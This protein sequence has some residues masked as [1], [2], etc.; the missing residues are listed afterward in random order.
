MKH[1]YRNHPS[2]KNFFKRT[3]NLALIYVLILSLFYQAT[4]MANP[5]MVTQNIMETIMVIENADDASAA[6]IS[7]RIIVASRLS[8]DAETIDFLGKALKSINSARLEEARGLLEM[9]LRRNQFQFRGEYLLRAES[10]EKLVKAFLFGTISKEVELTYRGVAKERALALMLTYIADPRTI[11]TD[12]DV[13]KFVDSQNVGFL[14]KGNYVK[15]PEGLD[16]RKIVAQLESDIMAAIPK[17]LPLNYSVKQDGPSGFRTYIEII[18]F[19]YAPTV[20]AWF[21]NGFR[22][23]G[24]NR[25]LYRVAD[26]FHYLASKSHGQNFQTLE[27]LFAQVESVF[28]SPAIST[29]WAPRTADSVKAILNREFTY[30]ADAA[31]KEFERVIAY[32]KST[33]QS[34]AMILEKT[35]EYEAKILANKEVLVKKLADI[36]QAVD[37]ATK[38]PGFDKLSGHLKD[39]AKLRAAEKAGKTRLVT[40]DMALK[41]L[42]FFIAG[43]YAY[44]GTWAVSNT[45]NSAEKV[46]LMQKYSAKTINSLLYMVPVAGE[47]AI[48]WDFSVLAT[49]AA[50][51]KFLETDFRL[52]H[53]ED[54]IRGFFRL[55]EDIAVNLFVGVDRH[56]NNM[57]Y[58]EATIQMTPLKYYNGGWRDVVLER[59]SRAVDKHDVDAIRQLKEGMQIHFKKTAQSWIQAMYIAHTNHNVFTFDDTTNFDLEVSHQVLDRYKGYLSIADNLM[60]KAANIEKESANIVVQ[61]VKPVDGPKDPVPPGPVPPDFDIE[62]DDE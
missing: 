55:S 15:Y 28:R 25:Y 16:G 61:P 53:T 10:A 29:G 30:A 36:D 58:L 48:A 1:I 21:K 41:T 8:E 60:V 50:L 18:G 47:A 26:G 42:S 59:F 35:A 57:N 54:G 23:A 22:L 49:N 13:R 12:P 17:E 56:H 45:E 33:G 39:S 3:S 2:K 51:G 19:K 24:G 9:A 5:M 46:F 32:L 4:A 40:F 44:H 62:F 52:P 7:R 31:K 43:F 37:Q 14:I 6:E 11:L 38:A 34:E 27:K 20:E